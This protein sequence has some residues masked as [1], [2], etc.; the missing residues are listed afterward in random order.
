MNNS[1]CWKLTL[2]LESSIRKT[3]SET[4]NVQRHKLF[5]SQFFLLFHVNNQIH[6]LVQWKWLF[7]CFLFLSV[8][9]RLQ[10][11][12]TAWEWKWKGLEVGGGVAEI[13][14]WSCWGTSTYDDEAGIRMCSHLVYFRREEKKTQKIVTVIR[15]ALHFCHSY[16]HSPRPS[17]PPPLTFTLLSLI[18]SDSFSLE[19]LLLP[20]ESF[21]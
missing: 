7:V 12:W 20:K 8:C 5:D 18:L 17:P 6:F 13:S 2:T 19:S 15:K 10:I 1:I 3:E 4:Q 16:N 14:R 9:G 21:C 11:Q